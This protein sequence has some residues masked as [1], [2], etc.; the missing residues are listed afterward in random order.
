M[1]AELITSM[2]SVGVLGLALGAALTLLLLRIIYQAHLSPL[3]KIPGPKLYSF[4]DIPYLYHLLRGTWPHKLKSLHDR[5]GPVV[6]YTTDNISFITPEAW[7]IIYGH[8]TG[9]NQLTYQ[10]DPIAYRP[11]F[12]GHPHIIVANDADHRRQRRLLSHAFS[13]KAL[14]NQED[15]MQ[16]YTSLFLSHLTQKSVSGETVDIVKWYNFLTFDLIGDLA[17]GQSFSCL[18]TGN[19][20][21][22]VSMIFNNIKLSVFV[23]TLRRYPFLSILKSVLLPKKLVKSQL[24]HW[25]LSR[26]TAKKRLL[27]GG[28][29]RGDFMSYILRYNEGDEKG[30]SEGEIIENTNLLIIAGSETTATQLSGTTFWL[31]MDKE[32]RYERLVN[33]IRGRFADEKEITLQAV[34]GLEYMDACFEEA[35]RMYPPV[36]LALPRRTPGKGE[37]IEGYWVPGGT[38]VAVPQWASYQSERNFKDANKFIPE[39]WLGGPKYANDVR[40]VLQPFSIGPR[41]CIGKNLAYAEMRLILARLMWNFDLELMPESENWNDQK[42]YTLWEKGAINV[43]LTPVVRESTGK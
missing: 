16:H 37:Y 9:P 17:F 21:P 41:N 15:I 14:R 31:L 11:S 42:I 27:S 25:E 32:G 20:H 19:Y 5:Y 8:R 24:E 2:H 3:S 12:S 26:Q 1:A 22:W 6:R 36:P 28:T 18:S 33:E 23:E 29:E 39:R 40:G 34:G 4:W 7:K 10:K 43:K 13:E 30:M 38:A 35:F